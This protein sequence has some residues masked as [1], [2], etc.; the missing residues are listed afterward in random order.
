MVYHVQGLPRPVDPIA[1]WATVTTPKPALEPQNIIDACNQ[2]IGHLD[3][4]IARAEAEAPPKVGV[5][6]M[7]PLVWGAAKG[8]W[9]D[10][11]YKQAVHTAADAVVQH[12]RSIT[13]RRDGSDTSLW[14]QLFSSEAPKPGSP[15]LRWPG[16]PSDQTVKTM[17]DGLQRFAP[18]VQMVVRNTA[19]HGQDEMSEQEAAERLAT[20][21]LLARRVEE[22]KLDEAPA[23]SCDGGA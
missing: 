8:L 11:H 12:A 13:G 17:N 15:R 2:M 21:S 4:L 22:C 7:H 10:G 14:Q 9:R 5:A 23:S 16:N 20:L 18:G 1:A 19:S 6:G 3:D